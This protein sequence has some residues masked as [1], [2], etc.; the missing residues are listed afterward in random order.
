MENYEPS[1]SF[2]EDPAGINDDEPFTSMDN[3]VSIY[4]R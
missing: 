3:V 1:M 2:G 4:G